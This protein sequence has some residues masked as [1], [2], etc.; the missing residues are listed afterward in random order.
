MAQTY[1]NLDKDYLINHY[2]FKSMREG[3]ILTNDFGSWI[4][5][6]K[7]EFALLRLNKISQN[8]ALFSLLKEKG[9]VITENSI[10]KTASD[11]K[12][13]CASLSRGTYHHVIFLGDDASDYNLDNLIKIVN[14]IL[15]TPSRELIIEFRE[16]I[17]GNFDIM[18]NLVNEF[19]KNNA[20]H[21]ILKVEADL[22]KLSSEI[23]DFLINNRF[24]VWAQVKSVNIPD[25]AFKHMK[26]LQ[27][28]HK[29]SFYIDVSRKML[30]EG[31]KIVDIFA[32]NNFN[33]FFIRKTKEISQEEFIDF[34]KKIIDR[35]YEM[36]KK[37]GRIVIQESYTS[38]LLRKINSVQDAFYPELN[39]FCTGAIISQLAYNLKGEI[40]ANQESFGIELFKLGDVNSSYTDI[41]SGE[42]SLALLRASLNGNAALEA[43]VYKPYINSCPVCN[44]LECS[45]II[46]KHP[47]ERT[48]ILSEMLDYLFKR[49]LFDEEFLR[50]V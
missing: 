46:G 34:W 6:D 32:D 30:A 26:E 44:Y 24:D 4:Y 10:D 50:F 37:S 25:E 19:N 41:V 9:F 13:R 22:S 27:R 17:H 15:Q 39:S 16:N 20:K 43:S 29:V 21:I 40:Y 23:L 47:S 5:L 33:S 3:F 8:S 31:Q 28:R 36:N 14:F 12:L 48:V 49:M 18:N 35:A 2:R 1:F 38:I 42:D 45:N 7:G 11:F